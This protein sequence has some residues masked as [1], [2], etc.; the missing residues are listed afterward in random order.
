MYITDRL[1]FVELHKTGGSHI[2]KWLSRLAPGEQVGKH[3]RVPT[4]LRNRFILGSIRNPWDWYV[5]LWGYG[6]S[7]QGSVH[8]QVT[9]GA[10]LSYVMRQLGREMG[11]AGNPWRAMFT[12][13][14]HDI[15]KPSA[16]WKATYR[17]PNDPAAFRDWLHM[18]MDVDRRY[19]L[20]EGYAFSPV[21]AWAGLLSYR[22][23]KLF[24]SLDETLYTDE[25]LASLNGTRECWAQSRI[26]QAVIRTE[27]LEED[28]LDSLGRAGYTL[29]EAQ[30]AEVRAGRNDKTNTSRREAPA[31]YYDA[32]TTSLVAEREALIIEHHGYVAPWLAVQP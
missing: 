9:R 5:S 18:V 3:N 10:D 1:V 13:M 24:T 31:F 22:Y 28:L 29:T 32:A 30:C 17:N 21:A 26:V 23:L 15:G 4:A 20:A 14:L 8:R 12:Q 7:G 19:D 27:A 2:G 16:R 25:R 11:V 6:C